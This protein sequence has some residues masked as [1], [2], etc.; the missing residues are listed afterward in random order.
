LAEFNN[1]WHATSKRN[2]TQTPQFCPPNLNTVNLLHYL[3]KCRSRSLD[4]YN[5][6]FMLCTA[7]RLRK[8]L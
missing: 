7:C 1:F 2:V 5:D 3:V 6:E 8:S 4:V